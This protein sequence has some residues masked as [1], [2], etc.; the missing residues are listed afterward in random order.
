MPIV[1]SERKNETELERE[2]EEED[3]N[4][5]KEDTFGKFHPTQNI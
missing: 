3:R 2:R 4:D 1:D 5:A